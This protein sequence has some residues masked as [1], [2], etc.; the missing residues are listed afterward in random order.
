VITKDE[1]DCVWYEVHLLATEEELAAALLSLYRKYGSWDQQFD[2]HGWELL[3]KL[4]LS[5]ENENDFNGKS[6]G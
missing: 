5:A 6:G 1:L 4:K 3:T 2:R